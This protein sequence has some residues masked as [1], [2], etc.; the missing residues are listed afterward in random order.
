[1]GNTLQDV[2]R[3]H[4]T[5]YPAMEVQDYIKLIYQNE[6]G[7]G[8]MI[9]D[10]SGSE[11]FLR[12]EYEKVLTEANVRDNS[13]N[14][15]GIGNGLCRIHLNPAVT[16]PDFL[17]LLNLLFVSTANTHQGSMSAFRNKAA[18]LLE[19]AVGS[20]LPLKPEAVKAYLE[21]YFSL[22]CPLVHHSEAYGAKY[23]PHYRVIKM[24]YALYI[25]A[26]RAIHRLVERRRSVIIA[27]DGRCG[28]GKSLLAG[29]LSEVFACNVFH[30]DDFFLPFGLRT[31][32]RLSQPGGNV[33]YERFMHEVLEPLT[34][35][36]SVCFRPF[37]CGTGELRS[38]VH[39]PARPI[40]IVEG[41][42]SLHPAL[43]T[44]YDLSIFLTC[45]PEIQMQRLLN[46]EGES[47]LKRFRE[48]WIPLEERYF[49]ACAI[50]E[51]CDLQLDTTLFSME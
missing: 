5:A 21:E 49:S 45:S 46:R 10:P 33:D 18:S 4:C 39:V 24:A 41:S 51:H 36:R 35:G 44:H 12:A 11:A 14:I 30:M 2:L 31:K 9:P 37:D 28:S 15:E 19:M 3:A 1:M 50:E 7:C 23:K 40:T 26:F 6:F 20:L 13:A 42:Y 34:E 22:G 17:P 48:E 43:A 16:E 8:H 38:H 27:V 25:P 29:L 47:L 32:E